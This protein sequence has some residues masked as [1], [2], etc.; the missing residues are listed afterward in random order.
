CIVVV[1]ARVAVVFLYSSF[2]FHEPPPTRIYA[3][4]L[5][6]ALPISIELIDRVVAGDRMLALLT[7]EN[8]EAEQAGFDDMY[9]I[10]TAAII[11]RIDRKST[12]LY[13]SH[14][15]ISYAVFCLKKKKA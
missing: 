3:L 8:A 5:H 2:L 1:I 15:K 11:H 6:D 13:S 7:V 4:S 12:R 14:V 10:G 9:E